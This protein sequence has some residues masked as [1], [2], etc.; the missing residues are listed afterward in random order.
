MLLFIALTSALAATACASVLLRAQHA[1]SHLEMEGSMRINRTG[2]R[3]SR[4]VEGW[5]MNGLAPEGPYVPGPVTFTY[6]ASVL[7]IGL[8]T[9]RGSGEVEL[10][11]NVNFDQR[12]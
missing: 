3:V 11:K 2:D 5:L 9:R 4:G 1:V 8:R 6:S 7:G 12:R 10:E